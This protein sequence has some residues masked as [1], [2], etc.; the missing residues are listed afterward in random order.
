MDR[1]ISLQ[2]AID[3][4]HKSYDGILDFRSDGETVA[5]SF[6]DILT[7]LPPAR[8]LPETDLLE[9]EHRFG[10]D[11]RFVVEDMLSGK[12]ERWKNG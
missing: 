10:S 9:L 11:V 6:E 4:A 8:P 12:E 7:A 2:A 3:A 5:Q 1:L